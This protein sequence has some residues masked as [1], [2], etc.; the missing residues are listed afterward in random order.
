[1]LKFWRS[2]CSVEGQ[3]SLKTFASLNMQHY[4]SQ[5][6]TCKKYDSPFLNRKSY[7][8]LRLSEGTLA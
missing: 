1:M 2:S 8:M 6:S 7:E 5:V 4:Y 3:R